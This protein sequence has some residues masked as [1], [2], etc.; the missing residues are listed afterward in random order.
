M[1]C[2]WCGKEL[3]ELAI[4]HCGSA[5]RPPAYCRQDGQALAPGAAACAVCGLPAGEKP[6]PVAVGAAAT[7]A[8]AAGAVATTGTASAPAA[9][10]GPGP[11][12]VP[13]QPPA[14]PRPA[15]TIAPPRAKT[16]DRDALRLCLVTASIAG[17]CSFF[18]PW[19]AFLTGGT[20]ITGVENFPWS[21][22]T[23]P[24]PQLL[25]LLFGIATI[26]S[27]VGWMVKS[28]AI[29]ATIAVVGLALSIFL[30][31]WVW[32][33]R[34]SHVNPFTKVSFTLIPTVTGFWLTVGA[35]LLIFLFAVVSVVTSRE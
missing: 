14:T 20:G 21:W 12:Q 30:L 27:L 31:R 6:T 33:L 16:E 2:Q 19:G 3:D 29:D 1:Y 25:F 15:A 4:H 13:S 17:V 7:T 24:C 23:P 11:G 26:L 18:I 35:G 5:D 34:Q 22:W 8:A 28:P 9:T 10:G 32:L